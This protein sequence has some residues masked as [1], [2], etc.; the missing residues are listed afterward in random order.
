MLVY[1]IQQI[2]PSHVCAAVWVYCGDKDNCGAQYQDCWLKHLVSM[3]LTSSYLPKHH[4][5]IRFHWLRF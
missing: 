4:H 2:L 5:S 3:L 1:R